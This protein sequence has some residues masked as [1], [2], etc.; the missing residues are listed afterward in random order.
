MFKPNPC[1]EHVLFVRATPAALWDAIT[2]PEHTK[3]YFF[4]TSVESTLEPGTPFVYRMADGSLASE[5]E[6]IEIENHKRLVHNWLIRY[7]PSLSDESSKVSWV[8]EPR[9]DVCKLTVRHDM[10]RAP[11]TAAH[12]GSESW[13]HI[14]CG[15]KTLLETGSELGIPASA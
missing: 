5:G 10:E 8:I 15:L 3:R 2:R 11:K 13:P 9:G 6:V 4:G 7:D 1:Q 12:V 14:L